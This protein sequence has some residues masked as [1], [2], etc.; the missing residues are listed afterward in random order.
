MSLVAKLILWLLDFVVN[1]V[2]G[3]ILGVSLL[4]FVICQQLL[5]GREEER[6]R[7]RGGEKAERKRGK[8]KRDERYK[9]V[10]NTISK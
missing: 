9:V 5:R 7:E 2:F 10:S 4:D 3:L 8:R 6:E 1:V